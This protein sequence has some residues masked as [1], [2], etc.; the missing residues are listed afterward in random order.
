MNEKR[1]LKEEKQGRVA[2]LLFLCVSIAVSLA[3]LTIYVYESDFSDKTLFVLLAVLRYSSFLVCVC[4]IYMIIT[5]I[6]NFIRKPSVLKGAGVILYLALI[7]Y[8]TIIF[9]FDAFINAIAGG[10]R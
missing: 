4:S 3:A 7:I 10:I 6:R 2:V 9:L 8:G 1:R 5:G